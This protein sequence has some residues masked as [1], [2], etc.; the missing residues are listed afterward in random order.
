MFSMMPSGICFQ[1]L[2]FLFTFISFTRALWQDFVA[3]HEIGHMAN[4][5]HCDCD[6][7]IMSTNAHMNNPPPDQYYEH[8]LDYFLI[9]P[10]SFGHSP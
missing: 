1:A 6:T 8:N 5:I 7:C 9:K 3:G 2:S 4:M 10:P